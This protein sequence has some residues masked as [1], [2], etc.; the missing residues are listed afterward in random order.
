MTPQEEKEVIRVCGKDYEESD[1]PA[2]I[3][4][5]QEDWEKTHGAYQDENGEWI[6]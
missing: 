2:F 1:I 4:N 3:R 5:R 6:V